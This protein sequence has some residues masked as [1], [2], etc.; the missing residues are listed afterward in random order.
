MILVTVGTHEAPFDRLVHAAEALAVEGTEAVVLQRGYSVL[1]APHCEVV[2]L[3]APSAFARLITEA[4]VVV[5]HAGPA[6]IEQAL[7]AGKRP[8]VV[9][10]SPVYAEHVD[11][12]QLRYVRHL[13]P[14]AVVVLDPLELPKV[15]QEADLRVPDALD[16]L[17]W[18]RIPPHE[19]C[20]DFGA[21]ASEAV[22]EA[23]HRAWSRAIVDRG[24]SEFRR[25]LDWISP[26]R[27][28]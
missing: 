16:P 22:G 6:T 1:A 23:R 20:A 7:R 2:D 5:T 15:V 11:D 12:H 24:A 18:S 8:I 3:L 17:G 26:K 25:V 10:R 27:G 19:L 28:S 9:P 21:V 13:G 4:R 14:R